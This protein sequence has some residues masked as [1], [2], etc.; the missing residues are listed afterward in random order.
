MT[1]VASVE[2]LRALVIGA[3]RVLPHGGGTKT[4]MSGDLPGFEVADLRPLSGV[5]EHQPSE[6]TITVRAGTAVSAL[7]EKLAQEGQYLPF[8][9]VLSR[10]GATVGGTVAAG[11]A[12][13]GRLRYGGV[14]DFILAIEM[15][16]GSGSVVRG[17][18]R[19]VKNAA[20]FDLPKLLVG[21]LGGLGALTQVTLKVFPEPPA[22]VSLRAPFDSLEE[23]VRSLVEL[24][25]GP[26]EI[27]ALE[28]DS[29]NTLWLRIRGVAEGL[30]ARGERL[31]ERLAGGEIVAPPAASDWWRARQELESEAGRA[32]V[33]VPLTP[34]R[35]LDLDRGC[36]RCLLNS[37]L[38]CRRPAGVARGGRRRG[39]R[40]SRPGTP[41]LV[42]A[43][44]GRTWKARLGASRRRRRC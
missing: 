9:P 14:R 5:V 17:G 36:R 22:V 20:G 12:G 44:C 13:C 41:Q 18:Q 39:P 37:S 26:Y 30:E 29:E 21:S 3:E 43:W 15:V 4:A 11:L 8:D 31:C 33:K 2:E 34:G 1:P 24:R 7:Q 35:I 27:D 38:W 16:D 19:V 10:A 40:C 42:V 23:A 6:F 32:L 25:R 28:L